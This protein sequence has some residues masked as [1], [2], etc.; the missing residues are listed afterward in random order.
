MR[1]SSSFHRKTNP[2]AFDSRRLHVCRMLTGNAIKRMHTTQ[3]TPNS[4]LR[5]GNNPR[6]EGGERHRSDQPVI[7]THPAVPP[8]PDKSGRESTGYTYIAMACKQDL[9]H[10][11]RLMSKHSAFWELQMG[12]RGMCMDISREHTYRI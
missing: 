7:G 12:E 6:I 1:I 4:G 5:K 8:A 9:P 2:Y 3:L 11:N 10:C